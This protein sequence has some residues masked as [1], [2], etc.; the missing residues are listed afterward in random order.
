MTPAATTPSTSNYLLE[1]MKKKLRGQVETWKQ[2]FHAKLLADNGGRP[3]AKFPETFQDYSNTLDNMLATMFAEL[4]AIQ[5]CSDATMAAHA[6]IA[7]AATRGDTVEAQRLYYQWSEAN[8]GATGM[9][10]GVKIV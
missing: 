1:E 8:F 4:D 10:A 2:E 5:G 9:V 3:S 7:A 6:A